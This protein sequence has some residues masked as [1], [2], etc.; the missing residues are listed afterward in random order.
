[1][2]ITDATGALSTTYT[3]KDTV[4]FTAGSLS[5]VSDCVAEVESKLNRGTLSTTTQPTLAQVQQWLTRAKEEIAEI[6]GFAFVRRYASVTTVALQTRYSLPPD[7][8]GGRTVLRDLTNN[9]DIR[10]WDTHWFDS[11]YPDPSEEE[12]NEPHIACIKGME[13]IL[14]PPDDAYSIELEYDRS[15]AD[16]TT[17]DFSWLPELERF[18]CCDFALAEAYESLHQFEIAA[19]YQGKWERGLGR[20]I[21]ADGRKRWK[22]QEYRAISWI[23]QFAIRSNQSSNS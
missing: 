1:M 19:M 4:A 12:S 18:R 7:Y 9:R 21:K 16:N 10:I 11:K 3:E 2:T 22:T 14:L 8:A 13:L 23:E 17:T 20:S 6:R 15:G 5:T